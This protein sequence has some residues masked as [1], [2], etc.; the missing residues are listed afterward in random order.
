VD[1]PQLHGV[2]R[3]RSHHG[4]LQTQGVLDIGIGSRRSAQSII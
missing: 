1:V 2:Q 3:Q 4:T